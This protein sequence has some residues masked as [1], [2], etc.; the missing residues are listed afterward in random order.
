M[1]DPDVIY[2]TDM[3]PMDGYGPWVVCECQEVCRG[4][5]DHAAFMVWEPDYRSWICPQ[6]DRWCKAGYEEQVA[7]ARGV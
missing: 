6:C 2:D 4:H 3:A 1:T 5:G 7:T